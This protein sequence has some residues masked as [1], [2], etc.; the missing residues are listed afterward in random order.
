MTRKDIFSDYN[1]EVFEAEF[2]KYFEIISR[3]DIDDTV[4]TIL[5]MKRVNSPFA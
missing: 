4:R 5:V 3:H 2:S 1:S